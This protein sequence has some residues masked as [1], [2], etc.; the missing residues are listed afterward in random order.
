MEALVNAIS[1]FLAAIFARFG[2]VGR[3]R[4]RAHL[5][6]EIKLLDEIRESPAFGVE[7]ASARQLT[8]YISQ[9]VA[10][11]SG[12]IRKRKIPW[13]TVVISAV[14]GL[15]LSYWT[16]TMVQDGFVWYAIFP[17][18]VATFFVIGGLAVLFTGDDSAPEE[19]KQKGSGPSAG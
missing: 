13:S 8:D 9:E 19:E 11:Y 3:P 10:R 2:Y 17:G 7:S 1:E 12:V 16:Y 5:R 6:D 18:A 4:R 15:P 14:I